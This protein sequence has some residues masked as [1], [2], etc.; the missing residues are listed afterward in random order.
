LTSCR[1]SIIRLVGA[2]LCEFNDDWAVVRRYVTMDPPQGGT[3]R[4]EGARRT[5]EARR[6]VNPDDATYTT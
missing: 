4:A 5:E 6:A 1:P 3:R 2:V